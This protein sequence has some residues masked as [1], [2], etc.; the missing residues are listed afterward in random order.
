MT[1]GEHTIVTPHA[2]ETVRG[3]VRE[4]REDIRATAA[5]VR[6]IRDAIIPAIGVDGRN[7]RLSEVIADV[8]ALRSLLWSGLV[9]IVLAYGGLSV[10]ACVDASNRATRDN[11]RIESL[12]KARD[13][14]EARF[15]AAHPSRHPEQ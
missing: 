1:S 11:E 2:L 13:D 8:R 12:I 10:K 5:D 3:D 15:R 4:N 14:M 6:S 9:T 7:G